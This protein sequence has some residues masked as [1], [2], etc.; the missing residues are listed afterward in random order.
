MDKS[1]NLI[2]EIWTYVVV[3]QVVFIIPLFIYLC[4]S[5][6]LFLSFMSLSSFDLFVFFLGINVLNFRGIMY[7]KKQRTDL[8]FYCVV[9]MFLL[10]L[11]IYF[12]Y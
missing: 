3:I 6:L 7:L 10:F 9:G 12:Y 5:F 2:S 4:G 11:F 8:Y 1:N